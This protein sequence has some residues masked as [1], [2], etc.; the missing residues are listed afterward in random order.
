M[1]RSLSGL[2]CACPTFKGAEQQGPKTLEA[3]KNRSCGWY[4][5]AKP[6]DFKKIPGSPVAYWVSPTTRNAFNLGVPLREIADPRK[7][8]VTAD[9]PR[10]IRMWTEVSQGKVF[11]NCE[12]RLDAADS[13]KKWFPYQKGGDFRKWYGNNEA[14]VNW[15]N[16]GQELL[17]MQSEGYKVGSTNHNLEFIFDSAVVWTKI[18]SSTQS[19]RYAPKG[20]LFDD[21]S[22]LCPVKDKGREFEVLGLLNSKVSAH[23]LRA[24]NPTLNL[25]PGN[26]ADIPVSGLVEGVSDIVEECIRISE[27]DWNASERSFAF[28]E[29][30]FVH[31]SNGSSLRNNWEKWRNEAE[32]RVERLLEL[33]QQNNHIFVHAYGL[34]GE[35]SRGPITDHTHP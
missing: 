14:V 29:L 28:S 17:N 9:N 6:D 7:G 30:P 27:A 12:S 20:F 21:A 2:T 13:K 18:T 11:L 26:L 25:N 16:D 19:F 33:E 8:M 1:C 31:A 24:T 15:E 34:Q 23:L 35:L 10:F 22:G 3:I 4:Y 32:D 5:A